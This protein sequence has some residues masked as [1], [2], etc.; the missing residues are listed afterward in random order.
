MPAAAKLLADNNLS[1]GDVAGSGKDGRVTKGDVLAAVAGAAAAPKPATKSAAAAPA[2]G[3]K[4][5]TPAKRAKPA[6]TQP[7]AMEGTIF[8]GYTGAPSF[9]KPYDEMFD[10][11]G[12]VRPA[13]RGIFKAMAE[14]NRA[15]LETRIDALG[16]A[17]IDQ[18]V[19]FSLSGKERPFPLDVVPR[20]ISAA[21]W[22]KLE[23][24]IAQRQRGVCT[25]RGADHP[26]GRSHRR[27]DQP[28]ARVLTVSAP[29]S[30][31]RW[32]TCTRLQP[33]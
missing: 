25:H 10:A 19:T 14:S 16:R 31:L 18:G 20:V 15:D 26:R 6:T 2:K 28:G 24:G 5:R 32:P 17:F 29:I 4:S 8:D 7:R 11:T 1:V 9:G 33:G 21:E 3:T 13:Y 27:G 23:G 30:L 12:E 22:H